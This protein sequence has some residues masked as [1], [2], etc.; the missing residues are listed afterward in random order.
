MAM[1]GTGCFVAIHDLL[2]GREADYEN[3]HTHEHMVERLA[4]PGFLRGLRYRSLTDAP[5]LCTIYQVESLATLTSAAYLER[6]NNPTP[7]T[8][9]SVPLAAGMQKTFCTVVSSHGHGVGGYLGVAQLAPN[10]GED[11]RL[12]GWLSGDILPKL[13]SQAGLCGAHHLIGDRAA[14]QT[15]AKERELRDEPATV[16]DWIVLIE[17]YDR[18]SVQNALSTLGGP[19]GFAANGG[20]ERHVCSLY[21]L[22]F[23]LEEREAK[24]IWEKPEKHS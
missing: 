18:P 11:K 19:K 9:Q 7:W 3:W 8:T 1:P 4:I 15:K 20:N 22:D 21:N 5:R 24:A 17:G 6:L 12:S 2:L 23:A 14:S 10:L 13:S 16:A